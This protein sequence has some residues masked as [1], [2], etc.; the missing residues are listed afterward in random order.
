MEAAIGLIPKSEG[1][2][3]NEPPELVLADHT[4]DA[5]SPQSDRHGPDDASSGR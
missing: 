2:A 1:I 5:D 4:R 3:R